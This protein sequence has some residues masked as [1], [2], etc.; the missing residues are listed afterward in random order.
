[1]KTAARRNCPRPSARHRKSRLFAALLTAA[2]LGQPATAQLLTPPT[3]EEPQ[4]IVLVADSVF[5]TGNN[6]L[7]A[8]GNVEA[9]GDDTRLLARE[10]IYDAAEEKIYV[11]GPIRIYQGDNIV[12][13][14]SE[15]ELDTDLRNGL[16]RSARMVL[17]Q[18]TQMAA[19]QINRVDDRYNVLTKTTVSSCRVCDSNEPPLW[20]IRAHRVVHDEEERQVYFDHASLLVRDVPVFYF[21]HLRMPDPTLDRARGFLIPT[22]RTTS[23]LSYGLKAPYFIPLGRSRDI[24]LTP[25]VSSET[26]TLELRYRQAF[27][28]GN[29][30]LNGAVSDDTIRPND[31]RS[32]LFAEGRF[33]LARDYVF[34]FDLKA[35]SDD[36]YLNEYDYSDDDR[37]NSDITLSRSKRDENTRFALLHFQSLR[38]TEDN[39]FLPTVVAVAETERRYFP[40]GIGGELRTSAEIHGHYREAAADVVGRD[41]LRANANMLWR[42]NWTFDNGLRTAATG[43]LAFDAF[44]TYNDSTVSSFDHAVTPTVAMEM[45]YPMSKVGADGATYILEPVAQL[46]WSTT[47]NLDVA[48]DESTRIEFDEGNLLSLSRFTSYDRRERG[49]R[50]AAGLNW[51]RHSKEDWRANFTIGQIYRD[52]VD[53]NFTQSSGLSGTTSDF[54]LAGQFANPNG[55]S[56]SGRTLLGTDGNLSKAAARLGWTNQRLWL[57]ASFIW[58]DADPA[59]GRTDV[60]S[61]WA[62]DSTYRMS[63]HWTGLFDWR[64]DAGTGRTA[65]AGVGLEYRNECMKVELSLS[66]KFSTSTTVQSDTKFGLSVSLLGFAVKAQDKSYDRTCG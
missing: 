41:V 59:E 57:D 49:V 63:Q 33:D 18:R 1:M 22:I 56:V 19:T 53:A 60:L 5:V 8:K 27:K 32:Y 50:G 4:N 35:T 47:N 61:E 62:L 11:K 52:T 10:I 2:V 66:R 42:R 38:D 26:K 29:I 30:E 16:L 54:L 28:K 13:L 55:L 3:I 48:N 51:S 17:S 45:R 12:I 64:F 46:A 65:E 31:T 25:Y 43:E 44:R 58:L 40:V 14:A 36:S 39:K 21:P 6:R 37:L 15:A 7:T 24:T 23:L 9:L 34:S 20:S